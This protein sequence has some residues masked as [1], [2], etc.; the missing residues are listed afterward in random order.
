MSDSPPDRLSI[1]PASPFHDGDSL[2]R[3]IGVRFK[4]IER[5]NVSEYCLTEGW[6]RLPAGKAVDRKGM[7]LTMKLSGPV[8]VWFK[9]TETPA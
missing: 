8:E 5:F 3:G 9:D 7:P 6:V 4:G 2:G 1:D